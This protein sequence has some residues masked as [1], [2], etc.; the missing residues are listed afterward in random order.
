MHPVHAQQQRFRNKARPAKAH[1][2]VNIIVKPVGKARQELG[3]ANKALES[4]SGAVLAKI[5]VLVF[6]IFFIQRRPQGLFALRGR[7]VDT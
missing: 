3:F 1:H 7:A 4:W 5:A 2:L 6:I